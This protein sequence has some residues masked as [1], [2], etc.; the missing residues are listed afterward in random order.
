MTKVV[1]V[2]VYLLAG[3]VLQVVLKMDEHH[4]FQGVFV[5][6]GCL[7]V[8]ASFHACHILKDEVVDN[9]LLPALIYKLSLE[10]DD[11]KLDVVGLGSVLGKV[12]SDEAE[13][14]ALNTA[15]CV[16]G[17]YREVKIKI[18]LFLVGSGD[19]LVAF[20]SQRKIKKVY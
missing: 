12:A 5:L 2:E 11:Y 4:F 9:A 16:G 13:D 6:G 3:Y 18:H 17:G 20:N 8:W 19:N 14:C 7:A 15:L 10:K 1:I